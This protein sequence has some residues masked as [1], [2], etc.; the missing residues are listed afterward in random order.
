M[1]ELAKFWNDEGG[2]DLVET[3]LIV[4]I[5]ALVVWAVFPQIGTAIKN[6]GNRIVQVINQVI[7]YNP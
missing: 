1:R 7:G 5:M 4:L 2:Q 3:I 6:A